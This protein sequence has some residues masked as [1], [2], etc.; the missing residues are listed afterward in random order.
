MTSDEFTY[1]IE[2]LEST[3]RAEFP[4]FTRDD[5]AR[6]GEIA[7]AVIREWDKDLAVDIHIGDELAF[8]A[9]L[10]STG[11]GNAETIAG[12]I[13]VAKH[14]GHSSLLG[15]LKRDADP[16]VAEGLD[17]S[18]AWWGG[19]IPIFVGGELVGTISTSGEPDD[20][21][22]HAAAEEALRRYREQL[23]A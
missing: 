15:R 6:L 7:I 17:G 1:T 8:R 9:Q 11:Q 13:R 19:S 16:S 20:R 5:A 2:Q 4:S 12:K 23:S 21:V 14:F 18:Y 3:P 22:D 10:G